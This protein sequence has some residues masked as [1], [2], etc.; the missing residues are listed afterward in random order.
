MLLNPYEL[1][2][3]LQSAQL[4]NHLAVIQQNWTSLLDVPD[5]N[6]VYYV[7]NEPPFRDVIGDFPIPQR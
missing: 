5:V 7:N 2:A 6:N 4:V 3:Y 1:M